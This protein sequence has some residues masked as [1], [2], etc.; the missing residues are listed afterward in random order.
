[1]SHSESSVSAHA[2]AL[3]VESLEKSFGGIRVSCDISLDMPRGSRIALIGPNGA[4]KTTFV[5]LV[6]GRIKPDGGR[7]FIDGEDVTSLR[8][9]ERTRRGL[10]RSFQ[11][12]R[13][14]H[15]F[16]FRDHLRLAV[17]QRDGQTGRMFTRIDRSPE[18]EAEVSAILGHLDLTKLADIKVRDAAYGQHR[19][20]EIA[21]ALAMRSKVLLLDEPAAG[22]A[23]GDIPRILTTL[24]MLPEHMAVLMIEHDLD[25]A[26]RFASRVV[27]LNAGS[28][29]FDGTP[30]QV[31][32][33]EQVRRA[34]LGS[35]ASGV[36]ASASSISRHEAAI[37]PEGAR[38]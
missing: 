14:F 15:D 1:M 31:M 23:R 16:T 4:G 10:V 26:L 8:K 20:L 33:D 7:V 37:Q 27:V 22:V 12:S 6:T 30:E 3:R 18:R 34:Y 17:L 38:A 32:L 9:E 25:L 13:L 29:L 28:I 11:I 19:L 2:P 35:Y 5:N 24:Q 36:S 21:I